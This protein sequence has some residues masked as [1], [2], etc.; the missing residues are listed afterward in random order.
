MAVKTTRKIVKIDEEKCN[1]CGL[2]VPSCAEGAIRIVD[3]KAR[4]V[5]DNLCDGLGNCL[6]ECPMDAITIEE[7]EAEEFDRDA[8][9]QHLAAGGENDAKDSADAPH[10][11]G[12]PGAAVRMLNDAA[13]AKPSGGCPGT[14]LRM[15]LGEQDDESEPP[16]SD[17]ADRP[18]RLRQWPTQLSLVP[19]TGPIWEDADVLIAADCVP[20]AMPDF[21]EKLLA[22]RTLAIACPKLDDTAPY[23][24]KLARVFAENSVRSVTVAH[25]EVPCCTGIV[26]VVAEAIRR[27]GRED[28]DVRDVTVGIDGRVK[29]DG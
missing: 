15:L 24:E 27:S 3:G 13:A 12:C 22:G 26:G 18:S 17:D 8:V 25:M 4:L 11:A 21:H 2:C 29:E 28:I 20:T 7:R 14:A 10:G 6:G 19:P 1:G 16:A 9:E 5:A 23:V